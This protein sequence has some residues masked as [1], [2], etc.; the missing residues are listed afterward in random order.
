MTKEQFTTTYY[1]LAQKAGERFG[2]N[3][4]IILAQAAIESGWGKSYGARVRRN[5]FGIT[6]AGPANE[7]WDGSYSVG[8]NQYALK[9]RIYKSAQDSFYDFARLIS[10][11]YQKAHRVSNDSSAYAQAI[12]YSPYISESNG[13]NRENYR[14]GVISSFNS[15]TEILKKKDGPCPAAPA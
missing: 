8:K 10:S 11:R 1:P 4:A 5:F 6:A 2:M 3:P 12:A 15:I 9:F 13:D 14:K 7:F